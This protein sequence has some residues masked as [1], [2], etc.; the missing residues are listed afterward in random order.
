MFNETWRF[1]LQKQ[2]FAHIKPKSSNLTA[3][4]HLFQAPAPL[5]SPKSGRILKKISSSPK[6][7]T[8]FPEMTF[9]PGLPETSSAVSLNFTQ[10]CTDLCTLNSETSI[11]ALLQALR[12]KL[13]QTSAEISSRYLDSYIKNN[14]LCTTKPHDILL[15]RLLESSKKVQEFTVKLLNVISFKKPGRDYILTKD[16][17]IPN[18][19]KIIT[20]EKSK[21]SLRT[22]TL[23]LLQKLSLSK[24][25]QILMISQNF[26]K[27]ILKVMRKEVTAVDEEMIEFCSGILMNLSVRSTAKAKFL[28]VQSDIIPCIIKYLNFTNEQVVKY[29]FCLL[30]SLMGYK[31]LREV[32]KKYGIEKVL[33]GL[34]G[35]YEHNEIDAILEQ[36]QNENDV[37]T[38]LVNDIEAED[39]QMNDDDLD[40]VISDSRV[41]KGNDLLKSRYE[42]KPSH[43]EKLAKEVFG[44]RDKI[45]RTPYN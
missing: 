36:V 7:S 4:E 45:P 30:Y 31:S 35:S 32:A 25:G 5:Q 28:E 38:S 21:S 27:W 29:T 8:F 23:S 13:T 15:D 2:V 14:L 42:H 24:T 39:I 18:L 43:P 34:R 1:D 17:V 6:I 33:K 44:S 19:F 16:S 12:W 41:L 26:I 10:I 20:T 11:C 40:D 9:S 22:Y 37:D 3:L